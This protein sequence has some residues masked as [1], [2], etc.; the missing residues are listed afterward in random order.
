MSKKGCFGEQQIKQVAIFFFCV[1]TLDAGRVPSN[2][3][4]RSLSTHFHV[5]STMGGEHTGFAVIKS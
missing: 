2:F 3:S 5:F 4:N 1:Q